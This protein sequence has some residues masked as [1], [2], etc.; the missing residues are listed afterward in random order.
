VT[1][2]PEFNFKRKLNDVDVYEKE[3]AT[4]EC[5]VNDEEAPVKWFKDNKVREH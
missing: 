2:D 1:L 3:T 4:F 5:E